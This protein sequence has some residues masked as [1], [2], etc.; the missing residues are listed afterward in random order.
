MQMLSRVPLQGVVM[1]VKDVLDKFE[2]G[3][4]IQARR[5]K[6]EYTQTDVVENTTITVETYVSELENGKVS[7]GRS[8][9]F[10]SLA[11]YLKLTDDEVMSINPGAVFVASEVTKAVDDRRTAERPP[12]PDSLLEAAK[13]YGGRFPDLHQPAWQ[14]YLSSFKPRGARA[15]TPEE[16]LDLYRD[17]AKH[18][19][20]P[21]GN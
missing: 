2:A 12:V 17:L 15:D 5:E 19:I 8:K 11:K 6:L 13:L 14:A 21:G 20:T 16:W 7:V 9:H 18:G 3:K 1:A 4:L 10:P